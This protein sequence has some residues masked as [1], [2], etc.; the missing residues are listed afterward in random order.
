MAI[1]V[2]NLK[3]LAFQIILKMGLTELQHLL[4][5]NSQQYLHQLK[6]I[7]KN[8]VTQMFLQKMIK[9]EQ[10]NIQILLMDK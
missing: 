6:M 7:L 3:I 2:N 4:C 8:I 1:K 9:M 5:N 10:I